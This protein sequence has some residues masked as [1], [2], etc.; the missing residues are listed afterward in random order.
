MAPPQLSRVQDADGIC[1]KKA[2][3]VTITIII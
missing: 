1:H 3:S 2:I